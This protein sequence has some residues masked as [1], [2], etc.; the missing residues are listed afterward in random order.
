LILTPARALT[1]KLLLDFLPIVA[2]FASFKWA[3]G[4]PE[5]VAQWLT[6]HL[7]F[8]VDGGVVGIKEAPVLLSTLIVVVISVLQI[9]IM[10]V[11]RK[12][13]DKMLWISALVVISLGALT[14]Y[15]HNENFIKWKPTI[16][17]WVMGTG[18][19]IS[20][21][22]LKKYVL[23]AAMK[24]ADMVVP[25]RVWQNLSW[26]WIGFFAFMG[27]LNLYVAFN[28]PTTTWVDFKMWGSLGLMLVFTVAQGLYLGRHM[29]AAQAPAK[30]T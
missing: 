24:A 10:K 26:G 3:E 11:M 12:P 6:Q 25:D 1:M 16:I 19:F 20:D 21:I 28:Y 22:L 13:I 2:F 15:F 18:L 7:G 29:D 4:N 23:R 30:D 14:V 5:P 27:V 9:L 8:L 17:Y